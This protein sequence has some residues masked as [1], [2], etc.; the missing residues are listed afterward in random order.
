MRRFELSFLDF[1]EVIEARLEF[2]ISLFLLMEKSQ[3]GPDNLVYTRVLV[4]ISFSSMYNSHHK[5]KILIW[6][7]FENFWQK[8]I[9][10]TDLVQIRFRPSLGRFFICCVGLLGDLVRWV[11]IKWG[12]PARGSVIQMLVANRCLKDAQLSPSLTEN[13]LEITW[14]SADVAMNLKVLLRAIICIIEYNFFH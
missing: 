14:Q 2:S 10:L 7:D 8:N 6:E 3:M 1:W 4:L 11:L 9:W 13:E 12:R 5:P